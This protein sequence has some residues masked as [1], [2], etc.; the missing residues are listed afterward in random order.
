MLDRY[1]SPATV[2]TT[3]GRFFG[4]VVGGALPVTIAASWLATA[5]DQNAGTWILSPIAAELE[6]I[7]A[8]W[9]LEIFDLPRDATVGFV[10]G[11]TTGTF[12]AIA[13]ARSSLLKRLGY[14]VKQ[15]GMSNAPP[16]RVVASVDIH[17]T[18]IAALGY[19]GFGTDQIVTCPVD[20]QG[21]MILDSLPG[22]DNRTIIL[23]QA[24]NINSGSFDPLVGICDRAK[25][26]GAWVHVDAAFGL[27]AR[28]SSRRCFLA[29]GIELADSW[30]VDGHKWLNLPQ[31]S[32]IYACRD[33][34]A[35]NDVFGVEATYIVRDAHR[36]PNRL[37]PELSR[38]AR[39]IEFWAAIKHLGRTGIEQLIDRCCDHATHFAAKLEEAGYEILNDVQLNQ[40]VFAC[41]SEEQTRAALSYIQESG[42]CWLGPT[43]WHGRLAMRI[44]VTSW[45]TTSNDVEQSLTVMTQAMKRTHIP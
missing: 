5:W 37:T 26:A 21:R 6:Q 18:N 1:G 4:F 12:S 3:G 44:S 43:H 35:V 19:A 24:G 30:S 10:T 15:V 29:E 39:G 22:L 27:W 16:L 17:P 36:Q 13:A 8:E 45:A 38:R 14:N 9:L 2:A 25:H 11:S 40:V 7:A 31:D 34:D 33:G 32:A 28:A 41:S 20:S 23:A 42:V